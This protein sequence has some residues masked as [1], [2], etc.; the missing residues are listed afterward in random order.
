M[1]NNIY[2]THKNLVCEEELRLVIDHLPTMIAYVDAAKQY[3]I[4]NRAYHNYFGA[5]ENNIVGKHAS[6]VLGNNFYNIVK[7]YID[8]A[9]S[10]KNA[11]WET[12]HSDPDNNESILSVRLI[13]YFDTKQNNNG[14]L[15]VI[16]DITEQKQLQLQLETLNISLEN[17]V[18]KRTQQLEKELK[19]RKIL[20]KVLRQVADQ[21]PLTRLLNRRSFMT[22]VNHEISRSHRYKDELAYMIIDIDH[23][24]KINDSYGHLTGDA[25]LKNFAKKIS[26]ILRNSDFIARIGGEEFAIALPNTSMKAAKKLAERIRKDVAEHTVQHGNNSINFTVSIGLSKLMLNEKSI[27]GMFGR[28]DSVLYQAKDSGRNR[29]CVAG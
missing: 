18:K 13:P 20:E 9:L 15:V 17:K 21:D 27:E 12:H 5:R 26:K 29:V 25:V 24:K 3:R 2:Q 16:E 6:E 10:G 28:A 22:R 1:T 14:Y 7:R 19:A 11:A 4:I 8:I 23:F